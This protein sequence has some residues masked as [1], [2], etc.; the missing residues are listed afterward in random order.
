LKIAHRSGLI[1]EFFGADATAQRVTTNR[2]G[3]WI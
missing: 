2:A 1:Q 3:L